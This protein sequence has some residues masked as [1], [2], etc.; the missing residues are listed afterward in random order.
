MQITDT[1]PANQVASVKNLRDVAGYEIIL[2]PTL[3]PVYDGKRTLAELDARSLKKLQEVGFDINNLDEAYEHYKIA[4]LRTVAD[5]I[6][7]L[8]CHKP[9][10]FSEKRGGREWHTKE[11]VTSLGIMFP[12]WKNRGQ[13]LPHTQL[14][15]V[16]YSVPLKCEKQGKRPGEW[17]EDLRK[18]DTPAKRLGEHRSPSEPYW[19]FK[20]DMWDRLGNAE[21][22]LLITESE[23]KAASL[24]L[25]GFTAIGFPGANMWGASKGQKNQLHPC[26]DPMGPM[27][28]SSIP[29][30]GRTI[31]VLFDN[32]PSANAI[33]RN[34][35]SNLAKA[36]QVAGAGKILVGYIPSV[37]QNNSGTGIDDYLF[38][39]LGAR[40][41][42]SVEKLAQAK[43]LVEALI[44]QAT[45]YHSFARYRGYSVVRSGER[46][47]G[48]L[49]KPASFGYYEVNE[50][51]KDV[52]LNV[53]NGIE[54]IPYHV[55]ASAASTNGR[56]VVNDVEIQTMARDA[57][58][59]GVH[60]DILERGDDGEVPEMP[61]DFPNTVFSEV[62]RLLPRHRDQTILGEF[63]GVAK[64]HKC[65]RIK[66]GLIN[67]T[68]CME[69]GA[70]W[71][72]RDQWLSP[73]DHRYLSNSCLVVAFPNQH[74]PPQCPEF[75][76]MISEGFAKDP[77]R[78]KVFQ[79]YAGKLLL[80]PHFK[81]IQR[82]LCLYGAPGSGKSTVVSLLSELVGMRSVIA[83][84]GDT[85]TQFDSGS[86]PGKRLIVFSETGDGTNQSK[87][88]AQA[89]AL[90]KSVS[91]GDKI[92]SE[93]KNHQPVTIQIT[94][95]IILVGN[96]PPIIPMDAGAFRRR[97]VFLHWVSKIVAPN[98]TIVEKMRT[99]EL[100]GILLWA[101]EGAAMLSNVGESALKTPEAC[102]DDFL[103]TSAAVDIE[104]D[105]IHNQIAQVP[106]LEKFL[107]V[108]QIADHFEKWAAIKRLSSKDLNPRKLGYL[109][110]AHFKVS[111]FV[112]RI[113]EKTVKAYPGLIF[114]DPTLKKT[115]E[116]HPGRS[117]Y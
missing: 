28:G 81:D 14:V 16:R 51:G 44:E 2:D 99:E 117:P 110:R 5:I 71:E 55:T 103:E 37:V 114:S 26:L 52:S 32:D 25:A 108:Q 88:S 105:F 29:I 79:M 73:H 64:G 45:P 8:G 53:Y 86:L 100:P 97:A 92:R 69:F 48:K 12:S 115:K 9:P 59:A 33:V 106:D 23:L 11:H 17:D 40:W 85:F 41:S 10:T 39:H 15:R 75:M 58:E 93:R 35:A 77:A 20:P 102:M 54:Y 89:G 24:G 67:V 62:R 98:G 30:V 107:S 112:K 19:L 57:Y 76:K 21:I 91:G 111:S 94:P 65:V 70:L 72:T 56:M 18:Y 116:L 43:E 50:E 80:N 7:L 87:F 34:S 83:L 84:N 31:V 46:I 104:T 109:L 1:P 90:I 3:L 78:M 6:G 82:F 95:D 60:I 13:V 74:E 42:G 22:P 38:H 47:A 68:K 49:A 66:T 36:L 27:R 101:L 4:P 113:G 63:T 61:N 96:T